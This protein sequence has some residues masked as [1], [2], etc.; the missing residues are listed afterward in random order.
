M[1]RKCPECGSD[2]TARAQSGLALALRAK[3]KFRVAE[4]RRAADAEK[5]AVEAEKVFESLVKDHGDC[6]RLIREGSGTVGVG[7]SR[8][9]SAAE[10]IRTSTSRRT[11]VPETRAST[12]SATAAC[13]SKSSGC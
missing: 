2:R 7:K 8:A 10:R 5:L 1:E 9:T 12:S 6:P 3:G 11:R 13:P 4:Y